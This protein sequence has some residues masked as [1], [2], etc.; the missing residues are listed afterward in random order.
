MA[1]RSGRD[2]LGQV[3]AALCDRCGAYYLPRLTCRKERD[4]RHLARR[5][6]W[7]LPT[8][9]KNQARGK[10]DLCPNCRKEKP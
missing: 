6:H 8:S 2:E 7:Q 3:W 9:P 1:V 4:L 5:A 10:P